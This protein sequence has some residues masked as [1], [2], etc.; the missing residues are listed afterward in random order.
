LTHED[1]VVTPIAVEKDEKVNLSP[2]A[3]FTPENL[4]VYRV[5][6][7]SAALNSNATAVFLDEFTPAGALVQS[8]AMP[9]A[10]NGSHKRLTASGTA[11]SEGFLTRSQDGRY[12]VLPGYDAA[13]GTGSISTSLSTTINRVI[14]RVDAS[15]VVDT[16]TALTDAMSG[17]NPRG[18]SSTNG[19][20]LWI[21]GIGVRPVI[22]IIRY[23]HD[24]PRPPWR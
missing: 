6:N 4:V 22:L 18:A 5:G 2:Q 16:T 23:I 3:A 9:T 19:T 14:G 15:G 21:S 24:T 11:T 8:I 13:P 12:L 7:G 1:P 20:D 17:G 10:V